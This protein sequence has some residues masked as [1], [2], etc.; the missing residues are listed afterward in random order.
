MYASVR[1]RGGTHSDIV[2]GRHE[3]TGIAP[4]VQHAAL[5][6]RMHRGDVSTYTVITPCDDLKSESQM[7]VFSRR[8]SSFRKILPV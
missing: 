2:L 1:H 7:K 5:Q 3:G 6:L 4:N 8:A